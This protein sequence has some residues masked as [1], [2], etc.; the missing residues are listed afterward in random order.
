VV[1]CWD[2]YR[3]WGAARACVDTVAKAGGA[4]AAGIEETAGGIAGGAV[5]GAGGQQM[6]LAKGGVDAWSSGSLECLVS[7][8][9]FSEM[10]EIERVFID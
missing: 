5:A 9:L 7:R 2:W 8:F 1:L 10:K 4:A 3:Y 6:V